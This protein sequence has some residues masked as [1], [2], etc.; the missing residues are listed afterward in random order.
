LLKT[1]PYSIIGYFIAAAILLPLSWYLKANYANDVG[2]FILSL[3]GM[4][5]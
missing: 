5:H 4:L 2:G 3:G 1:D